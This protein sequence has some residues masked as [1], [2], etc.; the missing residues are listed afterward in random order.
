MSIFTAPED[1][2]AVTQDLTFLPT[3]ENC[4]QQC[5][6]ISI[7]NEG[8]QFYEPNEYFYVLL[9]TSD[10]R[11]VIEGSYATVAIRNAAASQ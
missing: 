6:R 11:V 2:T 3:E 10:Q 4:N 8:R 9:S 1:Y 5:V 7:A